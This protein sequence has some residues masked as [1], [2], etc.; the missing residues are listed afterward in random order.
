MVE[1]VRWFLGSY[2]PE[3]QS[4]NSKGA[5]MN[6]AI[7][8]NGIEVRQP[9]EGEVDRLVKKLEKLLKTYAPDLVQ[10]HGRFDKHPRKVEYNFSL[11]LSLPTGTLHSVGVGADLR[12]SAKQAFAEL[13]TQVK[14]HQS[15]LRHDYEWKRKRRRAQAVARRCKLGVRG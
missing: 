6:V 10:L 15:K 12:L 8:Y 13:K 4:P 14:K 5:R 11:N 3:V 9:V 2:R 7:S 1:L